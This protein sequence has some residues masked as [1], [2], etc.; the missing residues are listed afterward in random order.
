M[1]RSQDCLACKHSVVL[2]VVVAAVAV[3]LSTLFSFQTHQSH[4][5]KLHSRVWVDSC[6]ALHGASARLWR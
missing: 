1:T 4:M 2:L 3:V 6:G 5:W